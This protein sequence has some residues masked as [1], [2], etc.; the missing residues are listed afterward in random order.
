M[1]NSIFFVLVV[2]T[3]QS[4][5]GSKLPSV[6]PFKMEIQQGNVVTSKMLLQLRPGM[7]R[8][9]VRY[10]MGTPLIVDS[11][12]DNRWDYFYELRKQGVVVEKRRVILDFDKDSLLAV[13]GDVI[14]TAENT[15]IKTIAE[16]PKVVVDESAHWTEKLKFWKEEA[17]TAPAPLANATATAPASPSTALKDAPPVVALETAASAN[18]TAA[19]MSSESTVA[20]S[21]TPVV[22]ATDIA[23]MQATSTPMDASILDS[24][25]KPT[26]RVDAVVVA[27]QQAAQAVIADLQGETSAA[28]I[29]PAP[30]TSATTAVPQVEAAVATQPAA[31]D[32]AIASAATAIN[33]A[34]TSSAKNTQA[35]KTETVKRVAAGTEAIKSPKVIQ[36]PAA[37]QTP[38][39]IQTP[40]IEP[41]SSAAALA[42]PAPKSAI[43]RP[44]SGAKPTL[45]L[46]TRPPIQASNLAPLAPT[47]TKSKPKMAQIAPVPMAENDDEIVPF[48]PEGEYQGP[49]PTP[50]EMLKG[51]AEELV[52]PM[53][54]ASTQTVTEK[55]VAP[56]VKAEAEA[57]FI[58]EQL[59]EPAIEPA[60]QAEAPLVIPPAVIAA[61]EKAKAEMAKL[62][63]LKA[64][65]AKAEAAKAAAATAEL[66]Q[67]EIAQADLGNVEAL[68]QTQAQ[69]IAPS[70]SVPLA[71]SAMASD[72]KSATGALPAAVTSDV[73]NTPAPPTTTAASDTS[74]AGTAAGS[75][76]LALSDMQPAT[77]PEALIQAD[78]SAWAQAWRGKQIKPYLAAYAADFVPEGAPSKQVWEAQRRQRLSGKQGDIRLVLKDM[79]VKQDGNIASVQFEQQY[80]AKNYSDKLIKTLQMRFD[81]VLGHWLIIR[82]QTAPISRLASAEGVNAESAGIQPT[83]KV[84]AMPDSA[85]VVAAP[86]TASMASL[87]DA[88]ASVA[89]WAQAWQRK[90]IAAYLAAYAPE[91]TPEGLPSRKAWVAQR[92]SRLSPKQGPITVELSDVVVEQSETTAK[93][94]FHQ[95]YS[96]KAYRDETQKILQ[97]RF[98]STANAWL[99]VKETTRVDATQQ[100]VTAPAASV[101]PADNV[102]DP[103]GF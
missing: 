48:I 17:A 6:K 15:D 85:T 78:V 1:R 37:I 96:A 26:A 47:V 50:D 92:K 83:A 64:E 63:A 12:R 97:L 16:M 72:D 31:T 40:S 56:A 68:P 33:A 57:V 51:N 46:T 21:V 38:T 66:P 36:P 69:A 95:K 34:D 3:I 73:A 76:A 10:I 70:A 19:S 13:R 62:E 55:G 5:C 44:A 28:A 7:T 75:A 24:A 43:T 54:E 18:N 27:D 42:R 94:S 80:S 82:E 52:T 61:R 87:P 58:A 8:S 67:S 65:L 11:F 100:A 101:T 9:Q 88:K 59:P 90:D 32:L 99:I 14:P 74:I 41:A 39:A 45:F 23:P 2:A 60:P 89:A 98:D 103:I 102:L 86:V 4:G 71:G 35:E 93:V 81:L 79:V 20:A 77:N 25:N 49:G 84:E 91:F 53:V 30:V 22:P 29:I